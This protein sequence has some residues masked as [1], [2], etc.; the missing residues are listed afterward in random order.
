[1]VADAC[2]LYMDQPCTA[3]LSLEYLRQD[4]LVNDIMTLVIVQLNPS[5]YATAP[6]CH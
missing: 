6:L 3:I 2:L 1:M 4:R 5:P